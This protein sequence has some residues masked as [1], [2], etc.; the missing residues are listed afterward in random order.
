MQQSLKLFFS[1]INLEDWEYVH[2]PTKIYS[3]IELLRENWKCGNYPQRFH[4]I[5]VLWSFFVKLDYE[6]GALV[7][8]A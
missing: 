4:Y 6:D 1:K 8:M 7:K 5:I 3:N 2:H